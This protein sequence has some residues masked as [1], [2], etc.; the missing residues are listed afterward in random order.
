MPNRKS[1]ALLSCLLL[2]LVA[3]NAFACGE[4]LFRVGQGVA[5]RQYTAPL[6]GRILAVARTEAELLM[7]QQLVA[8]GHDVHVVADP[9]L[10]GDELL[11]HEHEFDIVL[12]YYDHRAEIAAQTATASVT[13][14]PVTIEGTSEASEAAAEFERTLSNEDS[15]KQFLKVIHKT[16]KA[17]G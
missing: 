15:V 11:R 2:T 5:F 4:S 7:I 6:P 17:R 13:Y 3:G 8:A 1:T 10:V 14:L 12:A 9:N 16:L